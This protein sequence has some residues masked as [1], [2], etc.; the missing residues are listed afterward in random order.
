MPSKKKQHFVPRFYLKNFSLNSTEKML[1]IFNLT[2]SK[3]ISNGK[4][5]D[6]AQKDYFYG[7]DLIIENAL[8]ESEGITAEILRNIINQDSIS[9]ISLKDSYYLLE[10][11]IFLSERT[12]CMADQLD[13]SVDKFVKAIISKHPNTPTG[14]NEGSFSLTQPTQHALYRAAISLPVVFDLS[15]KLLINRTQTPFITSD[16]PVVLYNQ[17]NESHIGLACKG[18]EIFLP[19]S[20]RHLIIFFDRDVYKV[21]HKNNASIDITENA[22]VEALNL[23]Q[24]VNAGQNLYFN[25]EISEPQIIRLVSRAIRYRGK[26]RANVDEHLVGKGNGKNYFLL[27][28]Y[29]SE[30]EC[31]LTLSCIH[32]LKKAKQLRQ[33]GDVTLVRNEEFC[34]LHQKFL[35][36]VDKGQYKGNEFYTFLDDNRS[37]FNNKF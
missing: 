4:L 6:Q 16:H 11:T 23:L 24:C 30:L 17:L 18:L 3:F 28:T 20:P 12:A 37:H 10:F 25:E 33:K 7:R 29:A 9:V 32:T 27:R 15:Y 34:R 19:I 1:G 21:G 22:D 31:S 26:P 8:S 14:I 5:K 2:H 36:L 13:E 35:K